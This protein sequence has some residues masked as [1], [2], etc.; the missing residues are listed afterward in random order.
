MDQPCCSDE[1]NAIAGL[2]IE[3]ASADGHSLLMT[4]EVGDGMLGGEEG[5]WQWSLRILRLRLVPVEIPGGGRN[6]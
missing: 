1:G 2:H 5:R 6:P 4:T 3:D